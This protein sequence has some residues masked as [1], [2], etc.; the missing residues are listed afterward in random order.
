LLACV[1]AELAMLAAD[2]LSFDA[3]PFSVPRDLVAAVTKAGLVC[4]IQYSTSRYE[5]V[6]EMPCAILVGYTT[7]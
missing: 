1:E 5:I 3:G 6:I 7:T 2:L 4:A